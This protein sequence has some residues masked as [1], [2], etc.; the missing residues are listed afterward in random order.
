MTAIEIVLLIIGV[1]MMVASFFIAEKL[2]NQ[3]LDKVAELST[4]EMQRILER[5]L[6]DAQIKVDNMVDQVI[7]HSI[8]KSMEVVERALDKETN[9]KMRAI[10]EYSDTVLESIHKTH[11]EV[12]FLYSMLND[13]HSELTKYAG[14]LAQLAIHL[15]E[16]QEQIQN[17][18]DHS[19]EILSRSQEMAEAP[20]R[21][22][23]VLPEELQMPEAE[24]FTEEQAAEK[25]NH[26]QMILDMYRNGKDAV[27]IAKELGLGVGEVKLVIGLF[28]EEE[29]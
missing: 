3:D 14:N 2:S 9:E 7:D 13:K 15:E 22:E 21:P 8:E 25:S 19:D 28:R 29:L 23:P 4:E 1:V 12:M 5:S 26:N 11:N 20:R 17:T 16:L 10:T 18:V 27:E 6:N 24:F